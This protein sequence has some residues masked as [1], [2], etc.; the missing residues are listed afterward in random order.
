MT[1]F[2]L[3]KTRKPQVCGICTKTI[4]VRIL[5]DYAEYWKSKGG[6]RGSPKIVCC[7]CHV[8]FGFSDD[9]WINAP[10]GRECMS[11]SVPIV[12]ASASVA[13]GSCANLCA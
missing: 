2:S 1:R 5:P 11:A 3:H 9:G 4:P 12:G 13:I 8:L 7:L 10:D 6:E